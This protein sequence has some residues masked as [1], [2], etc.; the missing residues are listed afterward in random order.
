MRLVISKEY[1][2]GFEENTTHLKAS[3]LA[4]QSTHMF[5]ASN[6]W[7][8]ITVE[9]S[10]DI[11]ESSMLHFDLVA[12]S[13]HVILPEQINNAMLHQLTELFPEK[14]GK[15]RSLYMSGQDVKGVLD[16]CLAQ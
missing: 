7:E 16:G 1:K 14:S 13:I 6:H 15:L 8:D 3:M 12:D 4:M 9:L 5:I 2:K 11:P 10:D